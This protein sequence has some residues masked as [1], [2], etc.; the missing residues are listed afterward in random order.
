[1]RQVTWIVF[2]FHRPLFPSFAQVQQFCN[3]VMSSPS[4]YELM[5]LLMHLWVR[6][7]VSEWVCVHVCRMCIDCIVAWVC[8]CACVFVC[9]SMCM[10]MCV[11]LHVYLVSKHTRQL[12]G[13]VIDHARQVCVWVVHSDGRVIDHERYERQL[14]G[15]VVHSA[16]NLDVGR[17]RQCGWVVH[18]ATSLDVGQRRQCGWVGSGWVGHSAT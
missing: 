7:C 17:R 4:Q 3:S 1:M 12:C 14:R 15:W 8:M 9:I 5:D 2:V 10:S 11:R 16:T 18:S 13:W 6:G